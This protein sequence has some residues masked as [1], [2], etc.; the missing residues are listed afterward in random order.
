MISYDEA[1]EL[2]GHQDAEV[3][4]ALARREDVPPEILYFLTD[5]VAP[6]V[7]RTVALNNITPSQASLVLAKDGHAG[8]RSDLAG[9]IGKDAKTSESASQK[10]NSATHNALLILA[11]D[12]VPDVREILSNSIKDAAGAPADVVKTLA[13]DSKLEVCGPVLEHSPVLGEDDLIDIIDAGYTEGALNFICRRETV[14]E[15]VSDAIADTGDVSAI[16]D[17]LTNHGAQIRET[18]LDDL[19][20]RAEDIELWHAPMCARPALSDS[21]ADSLSK[22][23]ADDLQ[24]ELMNKQQLFGDDSDDLLTGM[25]TAQLNSNAEILELETDPPGSQ[26]FLQGELPLKNVRSIF[27]KNGLSIEVIDRALEAQDYGF[28]LAA[29]ITR[30]K[31]DES[32]ARRIFMEKSAKGIAGLCILSGF[33]SQ[34][35]VKVQQRMGRIAPTEILM[36]EG[37]SPIMGNDEALWQIDFYSK[38]ASQNS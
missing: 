32:T 11:E 37:D 6:E 17:L 35:V 26:D 22:F 13:C 33:S 27:A 16:A 4:A 15:K 1:K 8:V 10:P 19:I 5:D 20:D 25:L 23:V 3:R 36:P 30:T 29:L 34:L 2:A 28:V 7:R 18:T 12:Q 14:Q 38:L 31:C 9:K 24:K 21:A